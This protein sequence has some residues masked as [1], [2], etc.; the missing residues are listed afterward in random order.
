MITVADNAE[1]FG[2][3]YDIYGALIDLDSISQSQEILFYFSCFTEWMNQEYSDYLLPIYNNFG[4]N[5]EDVFIIIIGAWECG[6]I[7]D[8]VSNYYVQIQS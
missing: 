7:H 4:C 5:K 1:N 3:Y 8:F 6:T 2:Q